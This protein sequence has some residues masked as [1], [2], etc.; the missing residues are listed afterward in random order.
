M[1]AASISALVTEAGVAMPVAT[2]SIARLMAAGEV[3]A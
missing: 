3:P 1:A 2:E